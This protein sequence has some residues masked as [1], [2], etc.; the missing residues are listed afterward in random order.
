MTDRLLNIDASD[1]SILCWFDWYDGP[2]SGLISWHNKLYWFAYSARWGV[3]E[4]ADVWEDDWGYIYEIYALTSEQIAEAVTWFK[5]KDDWFR[6]KR[7]TKEGIALREWSGPKLQGAAIAKFSDETGLRGGDHED[8]GLPQDFTWAAAPVHDLPI[9]EAEVLS[10]LRQIELG[11][12]MLTP[13]VDP[14]IQFKGDVLFTASNGWKIEVSNWSGNFGG[15]VEIILPGGQV[16]DDDFLQ[17]HLQSVC[18]YFPSPEF[19]WRAYKMR[20]NTSGKTE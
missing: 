14:Q 6:N 3:D 4:E 19:E 7:L 17:E 13:D 18:H 11:E 8:H 9:T 16:L 10:I 1:L 12:V 20:D 2:L 15:I 5:G